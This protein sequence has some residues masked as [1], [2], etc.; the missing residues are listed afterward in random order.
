MAQQPRRIVLFCDGT[1]QSEYNPENRL[2]NVSRI[3]SYMSIRTSGNT[4]QSSFYI[5]G[6]GTEGFHT[7][8][9][10]QAN[11]KGIETSI[12]AGYTA[13]RDNYSH[14]DGDQIILL[15]FS[16]GAFVMRC[17]ADMVGRIGV[18]TK[19][20]NRLAD[21]LVDLVFEQWKARKDG[22]YQRYDPDP[23]QVDFA[24]TP[25]TD[26][27]QVAVSE[28][29]PSLGDV[30]RNDK[31]ALFT[32]LLQHSTYL[33][34]EVPIKVCALWDTV[35]AVDTPLLGIQQIRV[36]GEFAFVNS[37]LG[38]R[39]QH[40][41]HAL[42]LHERRRPFLPIVWRTSDTAETLINQTRTLR[43]CWFVGYHSDIGG[44]REFQGL[45]HISLAWMIARLQTFLE[46][47]VDKFS[48]PPPTKSSWIL[49][50]EPDSSGGSTVVRPQIIGPDSMTAKFR[51]AGTKHRK[52][53]RHFWTTTTFDKIKEPNAN[54]GDSKET[55]HWT[56]NVIT[57]VRWYPSC[58]ALA[59][60][61]PGVDSIAN[62]RCGQGNT[63][64]RRHWTIPL[65]SSAIRNYRVCEETAL[66]ANPNLEVDGGLELKLLLKWLSSELE[67]LQKDSKESDPIPKTCIVEVMGDIQRRFNNTARGIL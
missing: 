54:T 37:G 45:S 24:D 50:R 55:I 66:E 18:L 63:R 49:H 1:G 61:F 14:D 40:A 25:T 27:G 4:S 5:P 7:D 15:G 39:I 59:S 17:V 21:H 34:R 58:K 2:T 30:D 28:V 22:Q 48:N 26:D 3:K 46:F 53:R 60:S 11:A 43:Q 23:R 64:H 20:S 6:I 9:L 19:A 35:A 12:K 33:N 10:H 56:V 42:S 38:N 16:R 36:P 47:D 31:D 52:P 13:I 57:G 67:A 44:G 32:F 51:V 29:V 65:K 41:I 62:C 8:K